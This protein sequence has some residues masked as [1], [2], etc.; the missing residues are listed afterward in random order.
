LNIVRS[1]LCFETTAVFFG[2]QA[3]AD[4]IGNWILYT[5]CKEIIQK[6]CVTDSIVQLMNSCCNGCYIISNNSLHCW[7]PQL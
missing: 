4:Y 3:T 7:F 6:Q 2:L 1:E 5:A